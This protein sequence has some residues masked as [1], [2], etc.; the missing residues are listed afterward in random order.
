MPT[1]RARGLSARKFS[2][3]SDTWPS[4]GLSSPAMTRSSVV[5]P[6]PDGPSRARNSPGSARSETPFSA[7]NRPKRFLIPSMVSPAAV[8]R[9]GSAPRGPL[10]RSFGEFRGELPFEEG[11]GREREEG[12]PGQ[13]RGDGEG[14]D[15]VVVIV[16]HFH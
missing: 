4:S 1:L 12:E 14:C 5:L 8:R 2:P 7:G 11:L 9:P 13:E 10:E 15:E 6:E 16:E 3:S